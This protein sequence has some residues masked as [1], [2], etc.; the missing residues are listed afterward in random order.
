[1]TSL[2]P[3]LQLLKSLLIEGQPVWD[4]CCDH[5]LL[6]HAALR[7]GLFP[8]VHF[9]DQVPAII[10][11][12]RERWGTRPG[13]FYHALDAARIAQEVHGTVV[14]AGVGAR[15]LI[16]IVGGLEKSGFLRAQRLVLAPQ[17]NEDVFRAEL[18]RVLSE[19]WEFSERLEVVE[20]GRRR[21]VFVWG[22][23]GGAGGGL[24]AFG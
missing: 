11:K 2:S 19:G 9:V 15:T 3:R 4:L 17:K 5:G 6:G 8:E 7:S 13:A 12:L 23:V 16:A 20:G 22:R 10:D 18:E 24:G 21:S 14:G 1:M